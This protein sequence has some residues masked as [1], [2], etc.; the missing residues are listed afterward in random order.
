M[1]R[2]VIGALILALVGGPLAANARAQE[3]EETQDLGA[4][5]RQAIERGVGYLRQRQLPGGQRDGAWP[6]IAL[7]D[8]GV[9][10]L[11]TLAMLNAGVPPDDPDMKRA[12][13]Y[14]RGLRPEKTYVVALQ[15]MVF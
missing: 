15:P 7:F 1:L 4:Q 11:C 5:V 14:L 8:G 3:G 2:A 9:T 13:K 12:L 6:D 10:S